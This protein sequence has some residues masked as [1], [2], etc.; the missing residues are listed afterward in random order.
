MCYDPSVARTIG[1]EAWEIIG[2]ALTNVTQCP[3]CK[4][5]V[6][7]NGLP[8]RYC[9]QGHEMPEPV[10]PAGGSHGTR[11]SVSEAPGPAG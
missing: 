5:L 2:V 11:T 1:F 6:W 8:P 4:T 3:E 9:S 7:F 10:M